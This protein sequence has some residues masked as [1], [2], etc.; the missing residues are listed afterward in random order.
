[1]MRKCRNYRYLEGGAYWNR[2]T[3]DTRNDWDMDA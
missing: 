1:M 3:F 2:E